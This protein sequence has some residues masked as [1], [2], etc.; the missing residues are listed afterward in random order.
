MGSVYNTSIIQSITRFPPLYTNQVQAPLVT[1]AD[2]SA[3]IT[4]TPA[5]DYNTFGQN[6]TA[7]SL[8]SAGWQAT[9]VSAS[10]QYQ[11]AAGSSTGIY[12]SSNYGQTWTVSTGTTS[13]NITAI[14]MSASGQYQVASVFNSGAIYYSSNYGVTWAT[15]N[16]PLSNWWAITMSASGQ[17]AS[18]CNHGGTVPY[19]SINYGVT[20]FAS[21]SVSGIYY[22]IA[23]SASGQYQVA[24]ITSGGIYYSS[25]YGQNWTISNISSVGTANGASMAASGQYATIITT[26]NGVFITSNYGL[27]W[28]QITAVIGSLN[29]L[30]V[31]VSASGQY[32]VANAYG[33]GIYY[34]TNYGASWVQ[35]SAL[36]LTWYGLGMSANGQY[37]LNCASGGL[38]Y[39]SVTRFP[40]QL[41]TS[42]STTT[43][44]ALNILAPNITTGQNVGIVLGQSI[45]PYNYGTIGFQYLGTTQNYIGIGVTSATTLCITANGFVGIG[46]V[47]PVTTLDT[48][49]IIRALNVATPSIAS[50]AGLELGYSGGGSIISG[51]RSSG[52][53]TTAALTYQASTHGFNVGTTG[54]TNALYI[55]STGTVGI[56]TTTTGGY[57]LNVTGSIYATGDITALSDKRQKQNIV[58]LTQSLD[59]LTQL[60]GYSY[61]R[62]DYKQDKEH[63]GLIA[64]EVNEVFPQAVNYDDELGLYSLNYGCLIAPVI[65]AIKELK[66][67]V[68]KLQ[69]KVDRQDAI[70]QIFLDHFGPEQ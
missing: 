36:A 13:G 61:T 54:A 67:T 43:S 11:S 10:G 18:A 52:T 37:C 21:S 17:Y 42:Q 64:Q 38:V 49:G 48:V 58:P 6:W 31:S 41:I 15:S 27:T 1:Y 32:Q 46:T 55:T 8:P 57:T 30:R 47:T 68:D 33:T 19:Y 29:L 4:N 23:C 62:T 12:Y 70:I 39:Q 7:T 59:N 66:Q 16:A 56:N 60:I 69:E 20:W 5:L 9:A 22:G 25:N 44:T 45:S 65:Q 40:P 35:G 51:T 50:G 26:A 28:T 34:S 24:V 2:N 14:A 3:Q 63:I 53:L